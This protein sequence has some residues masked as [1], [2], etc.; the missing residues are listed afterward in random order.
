[1]EK[2]DIILGMS[3]Y[4][5][6]EISEE[7]LL[8]LSEENKKREQMKDKVIV[9]TRKTSVFTIENKEVSEILKQYIKNN[10][11]VKT[12]SLGFAILPENKKELIEIEIQN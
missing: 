7:L 2:A 8:F 10:K 1:M 4:Q 12:E 11:I 9:K 6:T 3:A 5:A